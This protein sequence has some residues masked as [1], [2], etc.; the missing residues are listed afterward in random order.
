[1]KLAPAIARFGK[2]RPR[3]NPVL[4]PQ[5]SP[6]TGL[7]LRFPALCLALAMMAAVRAGAVPDGCS[8]ASAEI[9]VQ[10]EDDS[11]T[12]YVVS[13]T[14]SPDAK[15][16]KQKAERVTLLIDA[17]LAVEGVDKSGAPYRE[18]VPLQ[19]RLAGVRY[20]SYSRT[21]KGP[22]RGPRVSRRVFGVTIQRVSCQW[23]DPSDESSDSSV[24]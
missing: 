15:A 4:S 10:T 7:D 24:N 12:Y 14:V 6:R 5:R 19:F 16:K 3:R 23:Q 11:Y 8:N 9:Q 21:V 17:T 13:T 20:G 1:M 2:F 18:D 22:I